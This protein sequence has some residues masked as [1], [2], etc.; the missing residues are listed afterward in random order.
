ML[1]SPC[2]L[3]LKQAMQYLTTGQGTT[4]DA[5]VDAINTTSNNLQDAIAKS[6]P[7]AILSNLLVVDVG[8]EN[9]DEFV[10]TKRRIKDNLQNSL[11]QELSE[12]L[13]HYQLTQQKVN[14]RSTGLLVQQVSVIFA[15][16]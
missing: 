1:P 9:D 11:M 10:Q 6:S 4:I 3:P 14:D 2:H 16:P 15:F 7:R 8:D 5:T 12:Y 13:R